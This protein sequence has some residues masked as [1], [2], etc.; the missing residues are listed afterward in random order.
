[1]TN[2]TERGAVPSTRPEG[3]GHW[4]RRNPPW[5]VAAVYS[6]AAL[7]GLGHLDL[8]ISRFGA[9]EWL[10]A[11]VGGLLAVGLVAVVVLSAS[12]RR[13]VPLR[14]FVAVLAA[15]MTIGW[16]SLG[17]V[18]D[19]VGRQVAPEWV[20]GSA[21]LAYVLSIPTVLSLALLWPLRRGGQ[22]GARPPSG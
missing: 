10:F 18:N 21:L 7:G 19:L 11:L 22:G 17:V 15:A 16:I 8:L 6:V 20:Y 14:R 5:K 9:P 2:E 1:M 13:G 3:P 4:L 12:L